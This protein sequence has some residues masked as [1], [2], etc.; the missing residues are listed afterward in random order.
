V[1]KSRYS[2]EQIAAALRQAEIGTAVA[3]ITR[4]LGVSEATFYVWKKRFG[5]LGTPGICELRQLCEENAKLKAVVTDL[6]LDRAVLQD[7]LKK[8]G[9]PDSPAD[10]AALVSVV[11]AAERTTRVK[12]HFC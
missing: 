10:G 2:D 7:V 12:R 4:K 1:R 11:V 9:E 3:D 5:S 6:T 8:S